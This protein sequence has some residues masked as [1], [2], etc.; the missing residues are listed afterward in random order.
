MVSD[1]GYWLMLHPE[2]TAYNLFEGT[3]YPP[4]ELPT[5]LSSEARENMGKVDSR[6]EPLAMVMGVEA[7]AGS[8]AF[9][10]DRAGER[11]CFTDRVGE[12]AVGRFCYPPT[13]TALGVNFPFEEPPVHLF[14]QKESPENRAF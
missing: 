5:G 4:V 13:L 8:K 2:S 10:L 7:G 1:W 11:A 12:M 3:N 6:L 14:S 9:P